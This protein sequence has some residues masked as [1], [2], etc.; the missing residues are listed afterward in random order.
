MD[1]RVFDA[2]F[3]VGLTVICVGSQFQTTGADDPRYRDTDLWAVLA[4]LVVTVP[5]YWRR[6]RP[7]AAL[8]VG[9]A[10][11]VVLCAAN[12]RVGSLP[13]ALL[14]LTYAASAYSSRIG[15]LTAL[16]VTN[17]ALVVILVLDTPDFDAGGMVLNMV[18]FSGAWLGGQFMHARADAAA[19]RLA[20]AEER[21]EAQRQQAARS[22]AE[23]R[24]RL[25]QELHDVV[26]HSMSVIAVQ[27]GMGAHIIDTKPDEAR[28][29][30]ESIAD[31]SRST[32]Q[33]MRRLLGVLRDEDGARAHAPAPGLADLGRLVDDVR[34]AG[35]PVSLA[36]EGTPDAVP[37]GVE[38]SV[39]RVVQ[40]GLTNVIK[41]AGSAHATVTVRCRPDEVE[42]EVVDD[43]RGAAVAPNGSGG[44]GLVGMR[45]RAA[46]WGGT[47][48]AGPRPGG[49]YRVRARLPYGDTR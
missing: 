25:A 27:A 29:A 45:E 40:E 4:G 2:V 8:L 49:G 3:T 43:G 39:Y 10:A 16:F 14:F 1:P 37:H 31:T 44:H 26:A 28:W 22:V 41:H 46:L 35:V 38:L 32:L 23:E 47:L 24:L 5:V 21:A 20:E 12:Y 42:V 15:G 36:V 6:H 18:L 34:G 13:V 7:V 9:T 33:E 17:S 11:I 30:L 19:A 48:D